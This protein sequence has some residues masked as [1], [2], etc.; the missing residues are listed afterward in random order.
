MLESHNINLSRVNSMNLSAPTNLVFIISLVVALVGL[1]VGLGVIPSLP[2]SSFWI[3][4]VGY[5][6]LAFG[7]LFKGA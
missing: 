1:L 4:V 3:V 2:I 7:C 5:A 6:V